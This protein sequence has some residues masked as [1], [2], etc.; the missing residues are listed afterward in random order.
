MWEITWI[1]LAV[2]VLASFRLTHLLVYDEITTFIRNPFLEVRPVTD[3]SGEQVEKVVIRG[4]GW[5]YWIGKVLSCH[6]CTGVWASL[7]T[8]S[9][10][11]FIPFLFPLLLL[12][13]VA[14]AA[15]IVQ[16]LLL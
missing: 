12:L 7:I 2:L 3:P 16:D 15:A 8:V 11:L 6:W 9:I 14:G 5:R 1:H 4:T 13:A 10:Y